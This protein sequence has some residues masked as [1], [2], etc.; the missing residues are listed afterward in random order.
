M[1]QRRALSREEILRM[2]DLED[3]VEH[4]SDVSF[5]PHES[6]TS[7]ESEE[8]TV[9]LLL[10]RVGKLH[11]VGGDTARRTCIS[12]SCRSYGGVAAL[13]T[14]DGWSLQILLELFIGVQLVL[15]CENVTYIQYGLPRHHLVSVTVLFHLSQDAVSECVI[16]LFFSLYCLLISVYNVNNISANS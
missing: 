9:P 2:L 13:I 4:D 12:E 16:C 10:V 1:N 5:S 14:M 15:C 3:P 8:E 7:S 6:D 11:V